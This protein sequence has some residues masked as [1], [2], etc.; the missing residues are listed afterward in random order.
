VGGHIGEVDIIVPD[1]AQ[2]GQDLGEGSDD[3]V[4]AVPGGWTEVLSIYI[5]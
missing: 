5:V 1:A 3:Q 4:L 2:A